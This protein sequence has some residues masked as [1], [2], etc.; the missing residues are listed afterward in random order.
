MIFKRLEN[1]INKLDSL[2]IESALIL[3]DYNRNYLTNFTGDESY[4]LVTKKDSYFITDGRYTEQ[5]RSEVFNCKILEYKGRIEDFIAGI[6]FEL[7]IKS[8]GIEEDTLTLKEYEKYKEAFKDIEIKRLGDTIKDLRVIKDKSELELID[9]A[10]G[11]ADEAFNYIL[12]FIKEGAIEKEVA[13]ELET[14]M[15]RLGADG[16]SF[17]TIVASGKRSSLPHGLASDKVIERG[18]FVTLDFGCIYKGYCSDMTRT[19]VVGKASEEQKEIYETVLEANKAVIENLK[20]N[21]TCSEID[22]VAREIIE[23]KGYGDKFVHSLGHGVGRE[24]HEL[25]RVSSSVKEVLTSGMVITDEPGIY[26]EGFG[27]VRIEDLL[28][29]TSEGCKVLSKSPKHLIEI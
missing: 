2:N 19:V 7:N 1:F 22:S 10:A 29:V 24:I 13:L 8:I 23:I 25:P 12:P 9:K 4:L 15:R 20:P 21:M 6:L 27:G 14:Y 16:V 18:D 28:V 5:A 11:I 26:I 17:E 3:N